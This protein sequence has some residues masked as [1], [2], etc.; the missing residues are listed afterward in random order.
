M[1][2]KHKDF[3]TGAQLYKKYQMVIHNETDDDT[4]E[5]Q[6]CDFLVDTPLKVYLITLL[7]DFIEDLFIYW[8][9]W[10]NFS[11]PNM[12]FILLQEIKAPLNI[13]TKF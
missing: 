11:V 2:S 10:A 6:F 8:Q 4:D 13:L 7:L 9:N 1:H 5:S 12:L 3:K